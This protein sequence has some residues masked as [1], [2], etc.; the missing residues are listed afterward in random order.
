MIRPAFDESRP[1]LRVRSGES[2]YRILT[3]PWIYG[4]KTTVI[5]RVISKIRR[6]GRIEVMHYTETEKGKFTVAAHAVMK[7][8][9][10]EKFLAM[11]QTAINR[12]VPGTHLYE[13]QWRKMPSEILRTEFLFETRGGVP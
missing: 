3:T 2:V 7:E 6:D 13:E 12:V 1:H 8:E 5:F 10:F 4:G 9:K 11:V